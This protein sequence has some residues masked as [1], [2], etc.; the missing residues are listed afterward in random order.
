[1][2]SLQHTRRDWWHSGPTLITCGILLTIAAQFS[3]QFPAV[4]AIALIGRGVVLVLQSRARSP[5]QDSLILL[6]L[7]VYCILVCLAIVAESNAVLRSGDSQVQLSMLLDH[8]AAI[9]LLAGL[10]FRVFSQFSQPTVD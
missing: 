9:V 8:S 1:M 4:T 6:N 2:P 7:V 5:Q 3:T 10:M